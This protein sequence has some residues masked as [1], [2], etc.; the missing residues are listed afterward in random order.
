[1]HHN[2]FY[3]QNV[4]KKYLNNIFL[5]MKTFYTKDV[6]VLKVEVYPRRKRAYYKP[7]QK[8]IKH[9]FSENEVK[10]GFY[11]VNDG[12]EYDDLYTKEEVQANLRKWDEKE[13]YIADYDKQIIYYAPYIIITLSNGDKIRKT[14]RTDNEIKD[15]IGNTY[16]ELR[17][18]S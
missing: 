8:T 13:D 3:L 15:Y 9:W 2:V 1:M 16:P 12:Y 17:E 10:D 14:F 6:K 4:S 18:I 5:I 7:G 11:C